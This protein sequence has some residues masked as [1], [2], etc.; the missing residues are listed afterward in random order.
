M[1]YENL[2]RPE[3]FS[4]TP[5]RLARAL[6]A[7]SW[8][9][10]NRKTLPL[11]D[12]D[13][14]LIMC[15]PDPSLFNVQTDDIRKMCEFYKMNK[16]EQRAVITNNGI[17]TP[18]TFW[19]RDSV[20]KYVV[21]PLRHHGGD[22]FQVVDSVEE[23]N[24]ATHYFS[25]LFPKTH[26]Y[27]LIF[28]KGRLIRTLTKVVPNG[29]PNDVPWNHATGSRFVTVEYTNTKMYRQNKFNA[30]DLLQQ[31]HLFY[32][33]QTA[34]IIGVDVMFNSNNGRY[35]VLECNFAPALT[36][37][38]NFDAVV[39]ALTE[40]PPLVP[41]V[42]YD[43]EDDDEESSLDEF[44]F[45]DDDDGEYDPDYDETYRDDFDSEE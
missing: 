26:E 6:G 5:W 36:I 32:P 31:L 20:C 23:V 30:D 29:T 3:A 18:D 7:R 2:L 4:T 45:D 13:R 42:P 12:T 38:D 43:N 17:P 37:D 41:F 11:F 44:E 33:I 40:D 25:P 14:D 16:K 15:W 19:N 28:V 35:A 9:Y 39:T 10:P 34:H 8:K 27:R 22:D 21:R 1:K 24:T